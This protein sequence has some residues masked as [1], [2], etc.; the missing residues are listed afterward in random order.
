MTK[1]CFGYIRATQNRDAGGISARRQRAIIEAYYAKHLESEGYQWGLFVDKS[2]AAGTMLSERPMGG[3]KL[4]LRLEPG[5]TVLV[6][7]LDL[8]FANAFDAIYHLATWLG[9]GVHLLA[10][11]DLLDSGA[12]GDGLA[13]AAR[14]LGAVSE[15]DRAT[16]SEK[17]KKAMDELR[18]NGRAL[19]RSKPFGQRRRRQRGQVFL[20]VDEAERAVMAKIVRLHEEDN[21]MFIRVAARLHKLGLQRN[22]RR[23]S[24]EMCRK[25][26]HRELELRAAEA[27]DKEPPTGGPDV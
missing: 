1:R 16:H 10:L 20:E 3:G 8:L 15:L 6:W 27:A 25:A 21:L 11:D 7:R 9:R 26:Y 19:N 4:A 5:D 12:L 22:G 2:D 24:P 13:E 23:W 18:R 14:I 17:I